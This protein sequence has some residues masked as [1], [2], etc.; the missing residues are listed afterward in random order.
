L[1]AQSYIYIKKDFANGL[2]DNAIWIELTKQDIASTKYQKCSK[3]YVSVEG[4]FD[5][6]NKGNHGIFN[7]ALKD[8]VNI[9]LLK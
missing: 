8:I 9:T 1:R 4:T 7:G 3:H 2:T 5:A 6:N